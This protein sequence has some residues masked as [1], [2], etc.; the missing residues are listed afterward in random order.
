[1]AWHE[2]KVKINDGILNE[3]VWDENVI[4]QRNKIFRLPQGF[5]ENN[6]LYCL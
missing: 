3:T 5:Y 1:M 2:W 4:I 6:F